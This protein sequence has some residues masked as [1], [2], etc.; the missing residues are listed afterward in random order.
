[1]SLTD[2]DMLVILKYVSPSPIALQSLDLHFYYPLDMS[3]DMS[4]W[5]PFIPPPLE[6]HS[7]FTIYIGSPARNIYGLKS[8]PISYHSEVHIH[9]TSISI[10]T[11]F[12][13]FGPSPS[14]CLYSSSQ[15]HGIWNQVVL[16][17]HPS[18]TTFWLCDRRVI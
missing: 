14:L 10:P 16:G 4:I 1:M 8:L 7:T 5:T 12:L 11:I 6:V 15:E 18:S 17:L 13:E 2:Y 9:S 3:V